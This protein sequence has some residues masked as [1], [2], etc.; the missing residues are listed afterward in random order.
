MHPESLKPIYIKQG[1]FGPYVQLGAP[2]DEEKK[3]ASLLKGMSVET[4]D[5]ETAV[6]LLSLPRDLGKHPTD[7]EPVVATQGRFGPYL[8]HGSD[9]RSLPAGVGLLE[10][11]LEQALEILAQPKAAGRGRGAATPALK[12][13]DESPVTGKKIE[14]RDGRYGLYVTDGETNASLPKDANGD[15]LTFAQALDLLAARAAAGGSKKKKTSKK[16]TAK[17]VTKGTKTKKKNADDGDEGEIASPKKSVK[18]KATKATK[19]SKKASKKKTT[20]E[21]TE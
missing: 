18:K 3:N 6:K 9:S 7:G 13:M 16:K 1:R 12:T 15:E 19:A 17:K 2:D 21:E 10:I 5:L 8:K 11:T 14:L 20:S 4:L